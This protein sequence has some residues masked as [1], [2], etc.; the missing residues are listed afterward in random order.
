MDPLILISAYVSNLVFF[1]GEYLSI[2]LI[3]PSTPYPA[4]SSTEIVE[5]RVTLT[6]PTTYLIK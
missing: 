6:R 5:G 4:I 3:R 2:A 1:C